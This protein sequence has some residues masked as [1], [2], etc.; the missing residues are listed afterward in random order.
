LT[1]WG[2]DVCADPAFVRNLGLSTHLVTETWR[3]P[4]RSLC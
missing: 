1:G 4:M 2:R 3:L